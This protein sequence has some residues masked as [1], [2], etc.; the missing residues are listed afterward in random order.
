MLVEAG[1][2]IAGTVAAGLSGPGRFRYGGIRDFLL[3]VRFISGDGKV[4]NAGGKVVKN[5]AG[6]DIPKF[7][8]GSMGRF[9]VITELTFKVFPEP[10]ATQTL[11]VQCDSHAVAL[12][13]MAMAA[14]SRWELDAIDYRPIDYRTGE[15]SMFLRLAGPERANAS[16]TGEIRSKWGEDVSDLTSPDEFWRSVGELSWSSEG[17]VAV[18]IP[19]TPQQFIELHHSF[20]DD[21]N[22]KM[23]ASVAANVAWVLLNSSE[24]ISAFVGQLRSLEIPAL[25]VRGSCVQPRIGQWSS[26]EIES[27]V[28]AAMDPPGKFPAF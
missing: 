3:G 16:I 4:I 12:D 22:V 27:D 23:H 2:T 18:K 5:A 10:I 26:F 21:P 20:A 17:C 13:R 1:A 8:V 9:G 24:S 25:V 28:K 14:S 6:F 11:R 7:L 19:T 15:Q